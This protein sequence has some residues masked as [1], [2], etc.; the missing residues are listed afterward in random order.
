[1][2]GFRVI[3]LVVLQS[4]VELLF[5]RLLGLDLA[6]QWHLEAFRSHNRLVGIVSAELTNGFH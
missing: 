5:S 2:I 3:V 4:F 6:S 1:M